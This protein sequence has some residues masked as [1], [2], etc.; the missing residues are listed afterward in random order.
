MADH[1]YKTMISQYTQQTII[2]AGQS[3]S[4]DLLVGEEAAKALAGQGPSP[5]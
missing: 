5:S 3:E 2:A 4:K 1:A